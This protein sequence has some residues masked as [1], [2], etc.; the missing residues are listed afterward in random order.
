VVVGRSGTE[1]RGE[2]SVL[3]VRWW[4]VD[5]RGLRTAVPRDEEGW[6][7]AIVEGLIR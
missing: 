6:V 3:G 1:E 7:M 2:V 4:S 5:G